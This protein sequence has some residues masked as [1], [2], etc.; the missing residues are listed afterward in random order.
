MID[1]VIHY[2]ELF[3][4]YFSTNLAPNRLRMFL[5]GARDEVIGMLLLTG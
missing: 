2:A 4:F 5:D 3:I 1:Q